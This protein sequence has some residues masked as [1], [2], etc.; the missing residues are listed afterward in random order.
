MIKIGDIFEIQINNKKR[1][2]GQYIYKDIHQ[3]P[4]IQIYNYTL[5]IKSKFVIDELQISQLLFPPVITGLF[6][7]IR[8]NLW[9]IVGKLPVENFIYPKFVCAYYHQET[10][11]AYRWFIWDGEKYTDIGLVLPEEYKKLEYLVVWSPFDVISRIETGIYPFPYGDL[12]Q[13][14]KFIPKSIEFNKE[15]TIK[16]FSK[17]FYKNHGE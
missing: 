6:A 4:L 9:H 17:Y 3:G 16:I 2:F 1:V 12:I 15:E 10:G 8:T 5:D 11:E 13:Y 14:N 7:A